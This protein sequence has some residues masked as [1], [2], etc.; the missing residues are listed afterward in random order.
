MSLPRSCGSRTWRRRWAREIAA[1]GRIA[2]SCPTKPAMPASRK[3]QK[4]KRPASWA[5]GR[6]SNSLVSNGAV[7]AVGLRQD[8]RRR[9][10][11]HRQR[12]HQRLDRGHE[13]DRARA[14]AHRAHAQPAQ[15]DVV[16]PLRGV[17]RGPGEAV[18]PGQVR[19]RRPRELPQAHTSTSA[20]TGPRPVSSRQRGRAGVP[21]RGRDVGVRAAR[22]RARRGG[23]PRPRRSAG[24]PAA[25]RTAVPSAGCARTS[26]SSR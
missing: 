5:S 3:A 4:P 13:L 7:G 11:D 9:A 12:P 17:E 22:G 2:A 19:D 20:S 14:A 6:R 18:E 21:R 1:S 15:V 16:P 26:T 10:L 25:A 24:S 23:A 8:P